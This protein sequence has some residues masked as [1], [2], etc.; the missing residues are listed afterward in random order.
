M[1]FVDSADRR[2]WKVQHNLL[3]PPMSK[4]TRPALICN[5]LRSVLH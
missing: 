4:P 3:W 5:S 1:Q 2:A